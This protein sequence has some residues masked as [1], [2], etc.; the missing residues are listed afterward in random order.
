MAIAPLPQQEQ[1]DLLEIPWPKPNL[2]LVA[3]TRRQVPK[4][5]EATREVV[6]ELRHGDDVAVRRARRAQVAARRRSLAL[7][8]VAAVCIALLA[9][10]IKAMGSQTVTGQVTPNGVTTGLSDGSLY[11]VQPGDTLSSIALRI[12]PEGDQAALVRALR[13]TVGSSV[14]VPGEHIVLP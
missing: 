13:S 7:L 11:V 10:P 5:P 3:D 4:G 2:R 8:G 14:V 9:L 12:N 1:F 6:R